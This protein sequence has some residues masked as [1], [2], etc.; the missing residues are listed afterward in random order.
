MH[1]VI[2]ELALDQHQGALI[3]QDE[4]GKYR[5]VYEPQVYQAPFHASTAPNLLALGT[6]G[7]GKSLMIR[8]DACLRCLMVPNFHALVL[9]RTMPE[10]RES[11]LKYIEREMELL[12]GVFLSTFSLAKFP[13]GSTIVFRHCE[14]EADILNFLS[15]EYGA[16]YFDE[17][18]TFTLQQFLQI[19]AAARAPE[20][21]G[22]T[23]VVRAGSN[24]LGCGAEWMEQWFVTKQ[25]RI[26][27]YPDYNPDDFEMQFSTLDQNEKINRAS[28][29]KRLRNLPEHV[30]RAWLLGEFVND[31]AYFS[32]FH[33]TDEHGDPWH[34]IDSLPVLIDTDGQ[35]KHLLDVPWIKVYRAIDWGYFPDPAVCLWLAILPNHRAIVFKERSWTRTLAKDVALEIKRESEGMKIVE[36]FCD[37]TMNIKEGQT[38]SIG[39]IFEQNGVPVTAATN[40]RVLYGYSVHEYLNELIDLKPK[41]QILKGVGKS[42]GC[43][44][45]I[46]T[47]GQLR[48]DKTDP[49][50]IA[51]GED[52]WVVALAYFCMGGAQ[53]SAHPQRSEIP[54]WMRPRR[55]PRMLAAC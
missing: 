6:R 17:L 13:N 29:E 21:A 10:L 37:P 8:M 28:Y 52:H 27:D 55:H 41:L 47:F 51:D 31:G 34:V 44:D 26:E 11:H 3:S 15:S 1:E 42:Y 23:A 40:D 4:A 43:A 24:P 35:K 48:M 18:S 38:Y 16:I 46:R 53:A 19:S 14:T 49:R 30:R 2:D 7:T 45:L 9:R 12:G 54:R 32:D 39:E 36:S 33:K 20:D 5:L 50:K 22:Y 25:V